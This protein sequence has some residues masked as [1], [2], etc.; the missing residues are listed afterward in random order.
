M[1]TILKSSSVTAK[2]KIQYILCVIFLVWPG[3]SHVCGEHSTGGFSAEL[4]QP[5]IS[6]SSHAC[7]NYFHSR[8]WACRNRLHISGLRERHCMNFLWSV[9][10]QISLGCLKHVTLKFSPLL[11]CLLI[12]AVY[13]HVMMKSNLVCNTWLPAESHIFWPIFV[14]INTYLANPGPVPLV[15]AA[16]SCVKMISVWICV[17]WERLICISKWCVCLLAKVFLHA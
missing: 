13:S 12:R 17:A 4:L 3:D 11:L 15:A 1:Q 9:T 2:T 16:W 5:S 7:H 6:T 8:T 14:I 10:C